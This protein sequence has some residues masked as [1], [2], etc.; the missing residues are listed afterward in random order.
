M[1]PWSMASSAPPAGSKAQK[2]HRVSGEHAGPRHSLGRCRLLPLLALLTTLP[3][4]MSAQGTA[5]PRTH[6]SDGV[7]DEEGGD[8]LGSLLHQSLH[9]ILEH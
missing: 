4:T 2:A 1:K 5:S 6:V 7:G 8:L 9:A 3:P